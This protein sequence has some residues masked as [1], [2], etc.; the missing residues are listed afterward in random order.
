MCACV[1][2]KLDLSYT[3]FNLSQVSHSFLTS[4]KRK[5]FY[6]FFIFW[7]WNSPKWN[8]MSHFGISNFIIT[9]ISVAMTTNPPVPSLIIYRRKSFNKNLLIKEIMLKLDGKIRVE[10]GAMRRN[11]KS[12]CLNRHCRRMGNII[13]LLQR[14][15]WGFVIFTYWKCTLPNGK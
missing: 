12:K 4:N 10:S 9:W 14:Y 8:L 6:Y 7:D 5:K 15:L 11:N 1:A 2:F 3:A 13:K